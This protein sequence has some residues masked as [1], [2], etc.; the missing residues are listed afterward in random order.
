[1]A[2]REPVSATDLAARFR[3][4]RTTIVRTLADFGGEL[5]TMGA[6]RSTRYAATVTRAVQRFDEKFITCLNGTFPKTVWQ[7]DQG[8]EC[9]PKRAGG[10]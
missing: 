8:T 1:M 4:N 3:V 9:D 7:S 5:V 10:A 6:T 2:A